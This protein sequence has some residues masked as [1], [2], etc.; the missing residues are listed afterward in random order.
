MQP[1][2]LR[3]VTFQA[4]GPDSAFDAA[5]RSDVLPELVAQPDVVDAWP[6]RRGTGDGSHVI[7][8]TWADG[9]S[10][11]PAH[12]PDLAL[13][14]GPN[15]APLGGVEIVS[16]EQLE[17]A[18]HA[19]FTRPEPARVLRVFRG[20]TR[21]GELS[22]YVDEA[23]AGMTEDSRINDGLVSFVLGHDGVDRFV[24][25]STWTGWPAIESATGGNTRQPF[26]TRN[27]RRLAD[28]RIVHLELLPEA[29]V[30]AGQRD[31]HARGGALEPAT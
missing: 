31:E 27:T 13:L 1:R 2:S 5:L 25:A 26:A 29:P 17:I 4:V 10:G 18:V 7:V 14:R 15:L 20:A 11:D 3:V 16:V 8:S 22:D 19:R 9:W 6:G 21:P 23:R 30:R 24:S 28:F 12:A